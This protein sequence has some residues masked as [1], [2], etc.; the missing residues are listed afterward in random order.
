MVQVCNWRGV[1]CFNV[2]QSEKASL[3]TIVEA[4][5]GQKKEQLVLQVSDGS[6]FKVADTTQQQ[7]QRP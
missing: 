3:I 1:V 5:T 6:A 7:V 4:E 2:E